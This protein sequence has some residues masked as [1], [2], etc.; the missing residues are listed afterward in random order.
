MTIMPAGM[1]SGPT[2]TSRTSRTA[3]TSSA[4]GCSTTSTGTGGRFDWG[5]D[6]D[7]RAG[8][9]GPGD[10]RDRPRSVRFRAH[11][12][13]LIMFMGWNDPVGSAPE[14]IDYYDN[15]VAC[16]TGADAAAKL[17]DTQGI[18]PALHDR[19]HVPHRDRAG[20]DLCLQRDAGIRR[21]RSPTSR[22]DMALALQDW[23]EKGVAPNDLI[24]THFAGGQ[25]P[26]RQDR[27]PAPDLR[28][29]EGPALPQRR[30]DQGDQFPLR[31]R[32]TRNNKKKPQKHE[33]WGKYHEAYACRSG[34]NFRL[35]HPGQPDDCRPGAGSS[36]P[37]QPEAPVADEAPATGGPDI[38]VT[39]SR[40]QRNGYQAPT[41][42]RRRDRGAAPV[43]LARQPDPGP[44]QAARLRRIADPGRFGPGRPRF[45]W[46]Q[47]Y[48]Q[49]PEPAQFRHD[50]HPD[51]AR[52][53][54]RAA[55]QFR[56][57]CRCRIP[58]PRR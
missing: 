25:R 26:D 39:G 24:A 21:R 12:G 32:R 34:T 45:G 47:Q 37:A 14:A 41:P 40:I 46:R 52:R 17:A 30:Q 51:P 31:R 20:R 48:R 50:P 29:P 7:T 27:L 36:P 58:C 19:R 15:V 3:P 13:K 35:R 9:D 8:R 42:D 38:V 28:L 1:P 6:V 44:Q 16:S 23:V 49:L 18:R 5:K 22:H 43:H 2:R 56:R 55:D 4:T 57:Q 10:Q 33:L 53:P 54:P 11:G